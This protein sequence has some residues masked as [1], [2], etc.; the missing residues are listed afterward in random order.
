M[1]EN[2]TKLFKETLE[3]VIDDA[4]DALLAAVIGRQLAGQGVDPESAPVDALIRHIRAGATEDFTWESDA[5][6]P[7]VTLDPNHVAEL[8]QALVDRIDAE[9]IR[10]AFTDDYASS[11]IAALREDWPNQRAH[12][13]EALAELR[14]RLMET[15]DR[16]LTL[17]RILLTC[18]R[19]CFAEFAA[20][21]RRSKGEEGSSVREALFYIYGR[22][23]RTATA[24][25]VLLEHGI[26]D[27]AY[28]RC[29]TLDELRVVASFISEHG[30]EAGR[31]YLDHDAVML[32]KNLKKEMA[33]GAEAVPKSIRCPIEANSR[34]AIRKHGESFRHDYGWAS[35]FLKNRRGGFNEHPKLAQLAGATL[36]SG[37]PQGHHPFYVDSSLQVHAGI[38]GAMGLA[39]AGEGLPVGHSNRGL[40]Q[41]LIW[42]SQCVAAASTLLQAHLPSRDAIRKIVYT[43]A[44]TKLAERITEEAT[45][46]AEAVEREMVRDPLTPER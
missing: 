44:L 28:A 36:S 23:L 2:L 3:S 40:E 35:K 8:I 16:P 30:D 19:E 31:R 11:L 9:G 42:A 17:F 39:S 45:A 7:A 32:W 46:C 4:V 34:A 43:A 10:G 5:E 37:K 21:S 29:R 41:P 12:E 18:S 33:W 24:V 26:A 20:A 13:D 27:E 15:W 22:M 1:P 38:T 6:D 25:R 14:G